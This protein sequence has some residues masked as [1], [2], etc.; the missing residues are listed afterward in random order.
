[1]KFSKAFL[2]QAAKDLVRLLA[3]LRCADHVHM[4]SFKSV[5]NSLR[6]FRKYQNMEDED[7]YELLTRLDG[8]R[9]KLWSFHVVT[10]SDRRWFYVS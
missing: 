3:F 7:V 9:W 10:K 4:A 8:F 2:D 5:A 1:M 6:N